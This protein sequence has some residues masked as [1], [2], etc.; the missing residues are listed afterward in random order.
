M[1]GA[2]IRVI[3]LDRCKRDWYIGQGILHEQ[4]VELGIH[5]GVA[6]EV[7]SH[8]AFAHH[9]EC[10]GAS[11]AYLSPV[12]VHWDSCFREVVFQLSK[13]GFI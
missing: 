4:M 9:A 2:E 6:G 13:S 1:R 3:H 10:L 11:V 12:A 5:P 8:G 7:G